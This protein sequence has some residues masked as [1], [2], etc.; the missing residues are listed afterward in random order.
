MRAKGIGGIWQ[1]C[2]ERA[3]SGKRTLSN[4]RRNLFARYLFSY[5]AA[6]L[7]PMLILGYVLYNYFLSFYMSSL[8]TNKADSLSSI[9][10]T[11]DI[12]L[13]HLHQYAFMI[14]GMREFTTD[15]Q[16]ISYAQFMDVCRRLSSMRA[17]SDFLYDVHFYNNALDYVYTPV[18]RF[19][20]A[21]Y[22]A[23]GSAY[24]A[25]TADDLTAILGNLQGITWL[26]M[27][28]VANGVEQALSYIVPTSRGRFGVTSAAIFFISKSTLDEIAGSAMT[29]SS[30]RLLITDGEGSILYSSSGSI[31]QAALLLPDG[32]HEALNQSPQ[33]SPTRLAMDSGASIAYSFPS[34]TADLR[35]ICL[36]DYAELLQPLTNLKLI[37]FA[38]LAAAAVMGGLAIF[39][40]MHSNYKPIHSLGALSRRLLKT[41]PA[42]MNELE[43]AELAIT[44]IN[45]RNAD[46]LSENQRLQREGLMLSLLSGVYQDMESFSSRANALE[47]YLEGPAFRIVVFYCGKR[48]NDPNMIRRIGHVL[49]SKLAAIVETCAIEYAEDDSVIALLSGPQS[50]IQSIG[51]HLAEIAEYF[52]ALVSGFAIGVSESYPQLRDSSV[53]YQQALAAAKYHM[54]EDGKPV[55]I[56]GGQIKDSIVSVYPNDSLNA[57]YNA[58]L[59][60]DTARI[61][62][63]IDMLLPYFRDMGSLFF[64]M[65]LGY[66]IVN[67]TLRAMREMNYPYF[68]FSKKYPELML[69]SKFDSAEAIIE[70]VKTL[71]MEICGFISQSAAVSMPSE[72][73]AGDISDIVGY[74]KVHY[75]DENFSIKT[76]ADHFGMSISNFSHH[77]KNRTGSVVSV[78]IASLRLERVKSLLRTTRL[79][80]TE[81]ASASGYCNVS[82][83]MRQF[84]AN[85]H[86]TPSLYRSQY[87][88]IAAR[89]EDD[90]D[91]NESITV[92]R[93]SV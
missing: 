52:S 74:I 38:G 22:A 16:R 73:K 7:I 33:D 37:F 75:T 1:R 81:I 78:Y 72:Q 86:T 5:V 60:G 32:F 3:R 26:P 41:H 83:L 11:I 36:I 12:Q 43:A 76:L 69:K 19:S 25:Y 27:Q 28:S 21:N 91:S 29:G 2:C 9:Q 40:F 31:E 35:Y 85:E 15:Y 80:L 56:Y 77:F 44:T 10:L 18:T 54:P 66:D 89:H 49:E 4:L 45:Q 88:T 62:F 58:I 47:A 65:C 17:S 46:I 67:T 63:A 20:I 48:N 90:N 34:N 92:E 51:Q 30:T 79:P 50:D 42:A 87:Q 82:T 93:R 55:V 57:L 68:Q 61:E 6:L 14:N 70:I 23:F 24:D 8:E 13:S 53:H 84:K 64:S 59:M 71:S 39:Y